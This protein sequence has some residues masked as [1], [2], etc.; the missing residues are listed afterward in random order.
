MFFTFVSYY[1]SGFGPTMM[2]ASFTCWWTTCQVVSCLATYAAVGASATILASSIPLR[3]YA[4]LSTSTP[5]KL[6]T[7]TW[8]LRISCWTV[9][10]TS[11]WLTSALLRSSLTGDRNNINVDFD[12]CKYRVIYM[13]VEIIWNQSNWQWMEYNQGEI[14]KEGLTKIR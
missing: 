1:F 11:A 6:S 13:D 14:L 7:A 2:S 12:N 10:D 9:K 4:P 8:S 5:K 3:L